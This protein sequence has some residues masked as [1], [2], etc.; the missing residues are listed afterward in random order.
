MSVH[1]TF[2]KRQ[3]Y[4]KQNGAYFVA[5]VVKIAALSCIVFVNVKVVFSSTYILQ[6]ETCC[7]ST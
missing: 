7:F 1:N 5:C 6:G 4:V 3:I 2:N